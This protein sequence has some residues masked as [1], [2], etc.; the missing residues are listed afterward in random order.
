MKV[1]L[2]AS[3]PFA[4]APVTFALFG[5]ALLALAVPSAAQTGPWTEGEILG[6]STVQST[7]QAAIFRVDPESG[8]AAV[9]TTTQSWGGWAGS[10]TFD[11]WRGG[12]LANASLAPDGAFVHKLWVVSQ[13]GS[14]AAM[15]GFTGS[16]RALASAG[17]GRV[18]F[19]RHTSAVQ[20]PTTI[21]YFDASD[22]IQTLTQSDG[23][24]PFQVDVEHLLYHAPSNALIGSSSA[25]WAATHCSP[26]G[27]S[28]Y[29]IP[30]SADG[31]RVEGPLT[32]VS[33]PTSLI[34]GDLVG[35]DHLPDGNVLV[36]S[37]TGF[38]GAPHFMVAVD[39]VTLATSS[40][41]QPAQHDV[42]GGVWSAR[43]GMAL[44]HANSGSAWW[45]P[46]GLRV[47]GAGE[48]G[49]GAHIA[50]SLPL[51]AGGGFSPVELIAE[52]DLNGPACAGF[53]IPTGGGLAGQGGFVPA[54]G[55][56]GCPDVGA[57]FTLAIDG[58]VGGAFG[59]LFL[60]LESASLP[61][62]GGTFHVGSVLLQ[63]PFVLG[64]APGVANA[65]SLAAP[66][67]FADPL[68]SGVDLFLQAGFVDAAAVLGVSLTNG[69]RLQG[70]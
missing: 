60:G 68:V 23:V 16:L 4:R 3:A 11:V 33:V 9:L 56:S 66:T 46:D 59:V 10:M 5:S 17:D 43:L 47:F 69:L 30:L 63:L 2:S 53:Q 70:L 28:L 29:R 45:E 44:V 31:L 42:N 14:A 65:G 49:F 7:G 34:Y 36:T 1:A 24:T 57:V 37:A 19:L 21:E 25:Q 48:D 64:G 12:V 41:A 6:R 50:T 67:V 8:A 40:W 13:D 26:T 32:C 61:F 22:V 38:L 18:F 35:L 62:K 54:I 15:P 20:G 39:P 52:V 27:G 51:P 55:I 58:V